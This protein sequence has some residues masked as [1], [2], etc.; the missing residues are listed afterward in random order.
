MSALSA[1]KRSNNTELANE[2]IAAIKIT[3]LY[4][5]RFSEKTI[6]I[7]NNANPIG[8]MNIPIA[9]RLVITK[10]CQS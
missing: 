3:Y 4:K 6:P 5:P 1:E 9:E 10:S 7:V 2:M 8:I